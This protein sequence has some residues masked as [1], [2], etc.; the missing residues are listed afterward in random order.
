MTA[1]H[2]KATVLAAEAA[3]L[4]V[5][6]IQGANPVD[7]LISKLKSDDD[8]VRGSAWQS[9]AP[10]GAPA[11]KPLAKPVG[12]WQFRDRPLRETSSI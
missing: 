2:S 8:N 7:D 1:N 10:A 12:G 11:V 3:I 6:E 5:S 9:A 4:T